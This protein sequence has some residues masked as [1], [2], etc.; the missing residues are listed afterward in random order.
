MRE[1]LRLLV[2]FRSAAPWL[3]IALALAII[4]ALLNFGIFAAVGGLL[5]GAALLGFLRIAAP[6]RLLLRY[7]ERLVAHDATFRLLARLRL[8]LL[9][10]LA[11]LAPLQLGYL[12]SGDLF[13][14]LMA[15]VE[16]LDG[17]YLR[18][19]LPLTLFALLLGGGLFVLVQQGSVLLF[20]VLAL[21]LGFAAL[22]FVII[23]RGSRS[24]AD[25]VELQSMLRNDVADGLA[26][27][28]DL[29]AAGAAPRQVATIN[30]SAGLL[31][32]AQRHAGKAQALAML[33]GQALQGL[34]VLIAIIA[35]AEH[36]AAAYV[37][38][39]LLLALAAAE[40]VLPVPM[41]L[42]LVG[43][44]R[45]AS[46]RLFAL[47][48]QQ[49]LAAEPANAVTVPQDLSLALEQVSFAYQP[50][51]PVLR[52]VSF[53]LAAGEQLALMGSSGS[54]KTSLA[55]LLLKFMSPQQGRIL[56]GGVDLA[57]IDGDQWRS[58]LG[59]LGQRTRLLAGSLRD[60]LLLADPTASE[61]LLWE[62]LA[63][64]ELA[65]FVRALPQQ[66]DTWVGE[67]GLQLSGGQARRLALA[68]VL[69]RKAPFWLLDEPLE[70]L[71][72][73]TA[74]AL[75]ETLRQ[76]SSGRSLIYITHRREEAEQLGITRI[77][78][79]NDGHLL[80]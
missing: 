20:P 45:A 44:L 73:A 3:A 64:V 21:L 66:L 56:V 8:W 26:G 33:W 68:M 75:L 58:N 40:L 62:V 30:H 70:G 72:G 28:A 71:D 47:A 10:R 38:P 63:Q 52:D 6:G 74:T 37:L 65:S 67:D 46:T 49:P 69:L 23:R 53:T 22:A 19:L 32:Q 50:G 4:V 5:G 60:N 9:E 11:R 16:A 27:M 15:D 80:S 41:S 51:L 34:L 13:S 48:D 43:R 39:V 57:A 18:L 76:V 24:Q 14:R 7:L 42:M 55:E 1:L 79:L 29:L 36:A 59:Y 35:T 54:G 12:R 78:R 61:A 25:I 31:V 2:L 17:F 77:L